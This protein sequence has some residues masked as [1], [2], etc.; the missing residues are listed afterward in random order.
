MGSIVLPPELQS[1]LSQLKDRT[2]LV[3]AQGNLVGVFTPKEQAETE[4]YERVKAMIDPAEIARR[5][6]ET[7]AVT[8]D[9]VK[10]RLKSLET[11]G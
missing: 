2:D 3:D 10:R 7:G 5:K 6:Q 11:S 9:E 8:Y 1:L 4:L